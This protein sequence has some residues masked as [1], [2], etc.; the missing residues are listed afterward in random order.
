MLATPELIQETRQRSRLEKLLPDWKRVPL[1]H[2][3][4]AQRPVDPDIFA[5]LKDFPL[6][7]KRE[8]R[9]GFPFLPPGQ[10][11]EHLLERD[12]VELE[13]TSG[14]SEEQLP[15]LFKRGW[16]D[17]QE[18]RALR[19]NPLVARVLDAHPDARRATLTTPACNGRV[20]FSA[21]RSLTHR[22]VGKTLYV[23]QHRIPFVLTDD[24]MPRMA[25]EIADW[26]PKFLDTDPVH[27]AWFALYCE[28][29]GIRFPS[30]EF[31]L[32]S[33]EFVSA[34]HRRI[35]ERAFGVPVFN[36]YGSTETG[37]LLM[38]EGQGKMKA[39]YDNAYL[40][41][42]SPDARGI[43]DL[44]VTTLTNYYMP[45]LRYRIGD[46]VERR[47]LPYET[48]YIVHGR[49]RDAIH[50]ANGDRV[51]TWDVDQC[52]SDIKGITHYQLHQDKDGDCRLRY[53][54][55]NN[56]GSP[57]ANKLKTIVSRL[58]DLLQTPNAIEIESVEKLPPTPSG[59]FRLTIGEI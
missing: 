7:G 56:A 31:I 14:T 41:I 27:A 45:L 21:W 50:A 46:L 43:G 17:L 23:N 26:S 19:L 42:V 34:V 20:C 22:T 48:T 32:C 1:Y 47:E 5:A 25:E 9:E 18:E 2:T 53:V 51:T 3:F 40:E 12:V 15:V 13:H 49:A 57:E 6:T 4:L 29:K 36:L 30:L 52:F 16:W 28:R 33:Y 38:Q 24:D 44:V 10:S 11:L 54:P 39:C 55:D 37:H 35:I 58:E 59:K 8:M